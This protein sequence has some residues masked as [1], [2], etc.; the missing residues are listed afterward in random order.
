VS[1]SHTSSACDNWPVLAIDELA[2]GNP[3]FG[4]EDR[5]Y[6]VRRIR[7]L[8]NIRWSISSLVVPHLC[9]LSAFVV[10]TEVG[11]LAALANQPLQYGE[12]LS[13]G[14]LV[15]PN[16]MDVLASYNWAFDSSEGGNSGGTQATQGKD[17]IDLDIKVARRLEASECIAM[18]WFLDETPAG[19]SLPSASDFRAQ[20]FIQRS[21]LYSESPK[22]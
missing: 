4:A 6:S 7:L 21:V 2:A 11:F 13:G 10:K 5:K 15:S 22:R 17:P 16:A 12:V 19:I 8:G 9:S 1:A 3:E 20:W 18:C 14:G